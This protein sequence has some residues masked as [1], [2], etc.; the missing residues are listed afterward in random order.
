MGAHVC[1]ALRT[2][3]YSVQLLLVSL[4]LER[5]GHSPVLYT[6]LLLPC[7]CPLSTAQL[8]RRRQAMESSS[9]SVFLIV[10]GL[11]VLFGGRVAK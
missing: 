10:G 6:S 11:R 4:A 2:A 9:V 1:M 8:A 3:A 5:L 7:C